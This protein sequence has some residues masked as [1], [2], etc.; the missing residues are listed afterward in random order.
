MVQAN[1][2]QTRPK[3]ARVWITPFV[4][5]ACVVIYLLQNSSPMLNLVLLTYGAVMPER[6]LA[7]DGFYTFLTWN[8]LHGNFW[9]LLGNMLFLAAFGPDIERTFGRLGFVLLFV[10]SGLVAALAQIY[11]NTDAM[12]TLIGAS[13]AVSGIM[14]AYLVCFPNDRMSLALFWFLVLP[15]SIPVKALLIGWMAF[16]MMMGV[17]SLGNMEGGVAYW[18]HL[19]GFAMGAALTGLLIVLHVIDPVKTVRLP[20]HD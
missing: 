5:V 2:D 18:A 17:M 16:Q 11:S 19:G 7:A 15:I 12:I 4:V 1:P 10:L 8:F 13:G 3:E 20:S 14:G 6:I 9:H